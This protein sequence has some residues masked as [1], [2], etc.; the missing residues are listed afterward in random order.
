MAAN[1]IQTLNSFT[2]GK[3]GDA[4]KNASAFFNVPE[5]KLES[6]SFSWNEGT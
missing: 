1:Q 6:W 4:A 3:K 5:P 2:I